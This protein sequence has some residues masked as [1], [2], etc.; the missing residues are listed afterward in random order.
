MNKIWLF[1]LTTC[2]SLPAFCGF[3][4]GEKAF[5]QQ[6]YSQAFSE[7][8]PLANEGDF[9]SQYYVGYLYV[10]GYGV[11][12]N[13][14]E[15]LRY[16]Q[17]SADQ[18]YDMAQ[19]LLGYLYAEGA[20]VKEDKKKALQLYQ[21][22]SEQNNISANLNLGIMYYTGDGVQRDY[23]KA[24]NYF[25]KVPVNEKPI[26][27]RYLG[28]IYL[29]N[30]TFRNYS[31]ALYHYELSARQGDLSSYFALGEMYRK[32][33]GAS[34]DMTTAINYYKYAA[35]ENY[36]PAQY[37]LGIVYANGEGVTRDI[38]KGYAWL[39]VASDQNFTIAT[40]ALQQLGKSMSLTDLEQARRQ[41]VLI[42]QNEM[43]KMDAPLEPLAPV[44]AKSD[45]AGVSSSSPTSYVSSDS[46]RSGSSKRTLRRRRR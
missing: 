11:N 9:R 28:S 18:N 42:Q 15:G 3:V 2:V 24:L 45:E 39:K 12:Q 22:A 23:K 5:T 17:D 40:E 31:K 25:N 30:A 10:Y 29:N 20:V 37:M 21:K 27:S 16:L 43:G 36:P 4:E 46:S 38:Y 14:Q 19:A 44:E 7:F 26:V 6:H 34:R 1:L 33:L 32:G 13:T 8:L 35:T 41:L